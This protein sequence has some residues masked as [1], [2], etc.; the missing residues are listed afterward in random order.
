[1]NETGRPGPDPSEILFSQS[2]P[3][4][5]TPR[6]WFNKWNP[7]RKRT[8]ESTA[9]QAHTQ[10]ATK[11]PPAPGTTE[12][13]LMQK[14]FF[15]DQIEEIKK[16]PKPED[17]K[18]DELKSLQEQ[19]LEL[20]KNYP[21]AKVER[22]T[23]ISEEHK[24]LIKSIITGEYLL[25]REISKAESAKGKRK[26]KEKGKSKEPISSEKIEEELRKLLGNRGIDFGVSGNIMLQAERKIK[27]FEKLDKVEKTKRIVWGIVKGV[28]GVGLVLGATAVAP[29]ALLVAAPTLFGV[30]GA[31]IGRGTVDLIR[32]LKIDKK[33]ITRLDVERH[34]WESYAEMIKLAQE[35]EKTDF[36]PN[37]VK[38]LAEF[39]H[40]S[41]KTSFQKYSA[42][43]K[44]EKSW[45]MLK[46]GAG[47]A[48]GIT[49][50]VTGFLYAKQQILEQIYNRGVDFDKD[51]IYRAIKKTKDGFAFLYKNAADPAEIVKQQ[52]QKRLGRPLSPGY[53]KEV[54]KL[55][56]AMKDKTPGGH[57]FSP[58]DQASVAK[59]FENA[60]NKESARDL[61]QLIVAGT[62]GA[63][64]QTIDLLQLTKKP[65][66]IEKTFDQWEQIA[67][68]YDKEIKANDALRGEARKVNDT[69]SRVRKEY[70]KTL[71]DE[72]EQNRKIENGKEEELKKDFQKGNIII[73]KSDKDRHGL[74]EIKEITDTGIKG[75]VV[76]YDQDGKKI[77]GQLIRDYDWDFLVGVNAK[78]A[79]DSYDVLPEQLSQEKLE[80][81][82]LLPKKPAAPTAE[83]EKSKSEP[84]PDIKLGQHWLVDGI[85]RQVDK[86]VMGNNRE[87]DRVR[88]SLTKKEQQAWNER[89]KEEGKQPS[90]GS[91]ERT[92]DELHKCTWIADP[93]GTQT[94]TS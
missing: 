38:K 33:A 35:A 39:M 91:I 57:L 82:G 41:E 80:K 62:C 71:E 86:I 6:E 66:E 32:G 22:E 64:L 61:W 2:K 74:I 34:D 21:T 37:H 92:F 52:L 55:L 9:P 68:K 60:F 18:K 31:L 81:L 19:L 30:G 93:P 94:S 5:E 73:V 72:E 42:W 49:S 54:T 27:D 12:W 45:G 43:Q 48:L 10:E 25:S 76:D 29:T 8:P 47:S 67:Q 20:D 63:I 56:Q 75:V 84:K 69:I 51:G 23:P 70:E 83:P 40:N 87:K 77:A 7:F 58:D 11:T 36:S 13:V 79:F 90:V 26:G 16:S 59:Y 15:L 65:G 88:L 24:R 17:M 3:K 4:K 53:E 78:K 46:A 85:N 14:K 28:L 89:M 50:A 44:V 1:M